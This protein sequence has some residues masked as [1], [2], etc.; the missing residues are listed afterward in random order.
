MVGRLDWPTPIVSS[1]ITG[2]QFA[3]AWNIPRSIALQEI[4]PVVRRDPGY[5]HRQRIRV[6]PDS[7]GGAEIDPATVDWSV[8]TDSTFAFHLR[9]DPGGA[10]PLGGVRFFL[11]S[12]FDVFLHDTPA[13]ALFREPVR[14]ASHG[15]VRVDRAVDLAAYLLDN[16][17]RWPRDS[18]RRAMKRPEG[19]WVA[20]R[21]P[22]PVH[23][24]YWTAW[25]D[26]DGTVQFRD[27]VYGWDGELES[28]LAVTR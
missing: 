12:R 24:A 21:R 5:L 23:L 25:V 15:C 8:V 18:I 9:Q 16:P 6:F 4:L 7:A 28:V 11:P 19:R 2:L 10:N 17:A 22:I 1:R 14:T 3:P 26:H 20:L 27:D 13:R